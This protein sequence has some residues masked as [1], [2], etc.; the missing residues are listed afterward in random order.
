[1][2]CVKKKGCSVLLLV[3]T[4]VFSL[5]SVS[6]ATLYGDLNS[7]G[8]VDA[9]DL[10]LI[11]SYL[12]GITTISDTSAADLN[13][14]GSVDSIDSSLLK[15]YLIGNI[16]KFPVE[17]VD[18]DA[19]KNNLGTINLGTTITCSGT[20][21]AV[22]GSTVKITAGG[23]FTVTGTLANGM[24]YVNTTEKV[25]LRLSGASITNSNGPAI[26]FYNA[27]KAFITL[28]DGTSNYLVD[29][30]T[31]SDTTAKGTLFS[32]DTLEIK[33]AGTLTVTGNYKHGIVS[34]D[35]V[36]IENGNITVKSAVKDSIHANNNVTINGGTLSLTGTSDGINSEGDIIINDGVI[37][38]YAGN[39][40]IQSSLSMT[41]NGG[42]VKVAKAYEGIE[43]KTIMTVN[44][45]SIN[46]VASEDGLC[47]SSQLIINGGTIDILAGKDAY[48]SNG[49]IT[50]TGGNA[51]IYGGNAPDGSADCDTNT[52]SISGGTL[53][54]MG[55]STS[56]PTA[57][58]STQCSVVL[59][60]A[61]VNSVVS[62]KNTAGTEILNF[63]VKKAYA[64]LLFTSPLL[65]S[66]TTYT[67]YINGA[68][69][70]TFT[71]SSMVTRAGGSIFGGGWNW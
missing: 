35:D 59:S 48:D 24:I 46:I 47:A 34:D 50:I 51:V 22:S 69:S 44:N 11:K 15:S 45:G 58:A 53:A 27:D 13:G 67:M 26:Y 16:T 6:A 64:T 30:K 32:N 28:I 31:Y 62:I 66:N 3:L 23:D 29:G 12:L 1:M 18:E 54:G 43:S 19:W 38:S 63:T 10:V 7:D 42:T 71:T 4:L 33:G 17:D 55:G 60:G 2:I 52:F 5:M 57:S 68:A 14:D 21:V 25:K 20:G 56:G 39:N 37:T 36:I 70:K 40:G 9:L 61:A 65:V 41:I 49:T 8:A